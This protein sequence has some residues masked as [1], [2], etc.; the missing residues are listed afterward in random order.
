MPRKLLFRGVELYRKGYA[1]IVLKV[2]NKTYC[3]DPGNNIEDCDYILCTHM[4]SKHCSEE[5]ARRY[6][7]RIVSPRHGITVKPGDMFMLNNM[8]IR[9]IDA[10]ND[11]GLYVNP[12]HPRGIGVGYIVTTLSNLR[13]YYMG[14]TN[15]INEILDIDEEITVLI[16]P[17]G[18]DCVMTP[19]EALEA[20]R[21]LKPSL[22]IPIHYDNIQQYYKFR[23]I[24]QPY[25]QVVLLR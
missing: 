24:A 2:D 1:G 20:V 9:V 17:I 10:Y 23:D 3:I 7:D 22:T 6:L 19:E 14:D 21:S 8:K 12:P 18:G 5:I 13:V 16:P 4:H 11:P 25:T 15:L